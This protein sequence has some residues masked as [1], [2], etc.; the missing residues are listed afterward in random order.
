MAASLPAYA[1]TP[2]ETAFAALTKERAA[3]NGGM[4]LYMLNGAGSALSGANA[5]LQLRKQP[6]FYC[7]P[8]TLSLNPL[9]YADIALAEFERNRSVYVGND[10]L[11]RYP[12]DALVRVLFEGLRRTFPC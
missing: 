7:Q 6:L 9:N 2:V 10:L 11:N 5:E 12:H 1:Q 8:Q 4:L 3:A